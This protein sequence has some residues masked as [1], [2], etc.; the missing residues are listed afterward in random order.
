MKRKLTVYTLISL[1][2]LSAFYLFSMMNKSVDRNVYEQFIEEQGKDFSNMFNNN[3]KKKFDNP[4]GAAFQNYLMTLDPKLKRVPVER[5]VSAYKNAGSRKMKDENIVWENSNVSMG[6]R[7]R[8]LMYDPNDANGNK[9]W[10]GSVTGGL[11]YNNDI[12][13]ETSRWNVVNDFWQSLSISRITYDPTNTQKFYVATGEAETAIITYRES[14]GRGVGIYTSDD[15]GDTWALLPSTSDFAY[16][17][18]LVV[19]NEAGTGVIY[20]SVVSG[21][22]Q[23]TVHQ[24]IPNDGLY[25][26]EDQGATWEQ[27][28]PNIPGEEVPY[29]PSDIEIGA[30]GRIYVGT[31]PNM[32]DVGGAVI[33]YSDAGTNGT[34][35]VYDDHV[36]EIM[37]D[38]EYNIPGR[39]KLASAASNENVVYAFLAAGSNTETIESFRT[40]RCTYILRSDNKGVSWTEKN[41]PDNDNGWAYLAWHALIAKVD[42]NNENTLF[43]GGLDLYKSTNGGTSWNHISDWAAMYSGGGDNYAHADQHEIVFKD[44]SSS[45]IIF[46]T[47]GGVFYTNTG[48]QNYPVF[49]QRNLGY[50]TLQFYTCA[51]HPLSGNPQLLG[52]LQD[53]GTVVDF[54]EQIEVEDMINGGDGAYCFYD[55]NEAQLSI[56]ST[57]DN[58]YTIHNNYQDFESIAGNS[59]TFVSPADYDYK[60]NILYANSGTFSGNYYNLIDRTSGIPNNINPEQINVNTNINVPFSCVKYSEHSPLNSSTLYL[61]SMSGRLF[62]VENANTTPI[63]T[64]ITSTEFP[65][66]AIS[67]ISIGESEDYMLVTFSNYGVESVF[68]SEDGGLNWTNKEANLPDIPVRWSI[69]HPE[70]NRQV[71]LATELGVWT[72]EDITAEEVNWVQSV[73]GM[74]N[75]RVDMLRIREADNRVVAASHGRGFFTTTYPKLD[76]SVKNVL[77]TSKLNIYPNPAKNVFT[78]ETNKESFS[79]WELT[80]LSGKIIKTGLIQNNTEQVYVSDLETGMYL[81]SI[82]N[83]TEKI[84]EKVFVE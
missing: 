33:L 54:G 60:L 68:Y 83:D 42:P 63:T 34:W 77:E 10:G 4:Q 3:K 71:M 52:G 76:V 39:V 47:D 84:T 38:A 50:N 23:G 11:W 13:A 57:Y 35:T 14:S 46:G 1:V 75:V 30:D 58:N 78:I 56:T 31:M 74:P 48:E 70:N 40:F 21:I 17:T 25:R 81:I 27:V 12:S 51:I 44:G 72:T 6:G 73:N 24:S 67:S 80:S 61:G 41:H 9:V 55:K 2:V 45:E 65:L 8:C 18:D 62:K 29:S 32:N 28:L 37:A 82:K 26:S 59:G 36:D 79:N 43:I 69:F 49:K 66:A 16:I 7:T 20:A 19:R 53:N 22:Y 64:E 15:G 5:L